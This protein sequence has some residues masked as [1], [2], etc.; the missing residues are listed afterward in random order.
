MTDN[1]PIA[2]LACVILAA[3]QGTRM[4]SELTK[5]LHPVQQTRSV[6]M[7]TACEALL[8]SGFVVVAAPCH[9]DQIEGAMSTASN[10]RQ[11]S[12]NRSAP[13]R[14]AVK[15]ARN[16]F[17]NFNARSDVIVFSATWPVGDARSSLTHASAKRQETKAAIVVAGFEPGDTAS[18]GRLVLDDKGALTAIVE[19]AD[20]TPEQKQI[21][22][23]NGGIM[24]FAG[25][26]IIGLLDQIKGR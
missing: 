16:E 24:L 26:K 14:Y 10:A 11:S 12:Q 21:K 7:I 2:P 1:K 9:K 8:L 13:A 20:A 18:F 23:C 19:T 4:K 17:K 15:A 22:L 5:V 25:D 3:G 6:P